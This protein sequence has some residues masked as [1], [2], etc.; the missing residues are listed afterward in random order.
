MYVLAFL[1]ALPLLARGLSSFNERNNSVSHG[2]DND[3]QVEHGH[4]G[5]HGGHHGKKGKKDK[6]GGKT[7]APSN[8]TVITGLFRQDDPDLDPEGYDMLKDSFGLLD[9][10]PDR[11]KK[12]TRHIKKLNEEADDQTTYKVVFIARHGEGYHNVAESVYGTPAWNCYW[13]LQYTDGNMTWGPDPLL[14]PLGESQAKS[15]NQGWK[16]QVKDGVPLPQTFYSSPMRRSASTLEITW[17]DIALDKGVRP[18]IKEMWRET[19]GLHTCDERSNKSLIAKTYPGFDF[20]P[21]F[22]E[23]DPLWDP[24]F[25]ETQTQLAVRA[26]LA[27]NEIFATDPSTFVSITAHSGVINAFFLAIGHRKFQVQTGGFVPVVAVSHPTATFSSITRGQ[28]ATAPACTEDPT[29]KVMAPASVTVPPTWNAQ[30]T[31]TST[32]H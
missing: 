5:S 31:P 1:S 13:S 12:F 26:R 28:S 22:T 30:A 20:E 9:K 14:T 19:I 4:H 16:E 24:E 29:A 21:S 10:S 25:E 2:I 27:L 15:A 7:L 18:V 11:W 3:S 8:V 17:R 32:S 6:Y 23:H